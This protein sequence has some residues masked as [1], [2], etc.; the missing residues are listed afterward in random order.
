M[1]MQLQ[2]ECCVIGLTAIRLVCGDAVGKRQTAFLW[3]D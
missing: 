2:M 3:L 1:P